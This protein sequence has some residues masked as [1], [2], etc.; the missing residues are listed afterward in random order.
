MIGTI[1]K[2]KISSMFVIMVGFL[3]LFLTKILPSDIINTA[4]LTSMCTISIQFLLFNMGTTVDLG[5]L[6]REWRTVVAS[7]LSMLIAVVACIAV[8]PIISK[9]AAMVSA[10]VLT[11]GIAALT[12]VQDAAN[13]NGFT[14][15]AALAAFVFAVQKFF[16]TLPA[17]RC[18]LRYANRVVEAM[19]NDQLAAKVVSGAQDKDRKPAFYEKHAKYYT[20]FVCL[21]IGAVAAYIATALGSLTGISATIWSMVLGIAARAFGLVPPNFQKTK[22]NAHGVFSW[23]ALASV[24]PSLGKVDISVVPTIGFRVLVIFAV[25][26]LAIFVVFKFTPAWRILGDKDLSIGVAMCQMIGYP[27]T[28]LVV[29]EIAKAVA[30]NDEEYNAI[31]SRLATAYVIS[32]FASVT[33]LS[34]FIAGL[35]VKFL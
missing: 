20:V 5:Q 10:P 19:R 12:I 24:I 29:D 15:A 14:E 30:Q 16:G 26:M 17:S 21:A 33:L 27:G 3:V 6:K 35:M 11:G 1:T 7:C 23:L 28:Q 32:G 8:I 2:A 22:G 34:V 31:E 9:E 18:G 4:G 25:A 13:A